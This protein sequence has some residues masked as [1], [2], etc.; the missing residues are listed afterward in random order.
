MPRLAWAHRAV[1]VLAG[2]LIVASLL[3]LVG[4][5]VFPRGAA[6]YTA[7]LPPRQFY[8]TLDRNLLDDYAGVLGV[9]HNS[10]DSISSA[11]EA[12]A[13]GA[14]VVEI[15]V[16]SVGS[17]L[18][19][20][21]DSPLPFVGK[22]LFRGPKLEE[23]WRE[24]SR[25]E[26]V[27][28]DLKESS[29]PYLDLLYEF[30]RPRRRNH[31]VIATGKVST[32]ESFRDQAPLATRLLSIGNNWGFEDL[33]DDEELQELVDG[34]SIR[35]DLLDPER[36]AWLEGQDLIVLA[37]T[38]ND[39]ERLNELVEGGVDAVVTDNLAIMELLGGGTKGETTLPRRAVGSE[40]S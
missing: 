38:V 30:L 33:R 5:A 6:Q 3:A 22:R 39:S 40:N 32:L 34:V 20:G 35:H 9:A 18:Y 26:A 10:G 29:G 25:A 11:R 36:M 7:G 17:T 14:D 8:R 27:K 28:L 15:D 1:R 19:A 24:A 2:V 31:V 37:W 12:L 13:Y 21:H 16:V 23:I 4:F